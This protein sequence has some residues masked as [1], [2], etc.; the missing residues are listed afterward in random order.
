MAP[1]MGR[2]HKLLTE[3]LNARDGLLRFELLAREAHEA[4]QIT[5]PSATADSK[6]LL[7]KTLL[8]YVL[9]IGYGKIKM[10]LNWKRLPHWLA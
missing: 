8:M 3:N 1:Y 9:T 7:L 5:Q 10:G 2:S 4:Q 6:T